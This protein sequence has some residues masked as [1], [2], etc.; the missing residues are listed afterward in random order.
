MFA[1]MNESIDPV[2]SSICSVAG[3]YF[4][5]DTPELSKFSIGE[6]AHA[7][8][9]ICRFTGHT[10][11]FYSVAQHSVIVSRIVPEPYAL[12]GL[13]HDAAEAFIGDVSTPLKRLLPDYKTIE[14]RVEEAV[15]GRF[16]LSLPLHPSVKDADLV[17]LAT[18][19][20]DLMPYTGDDWPCLF[21]VRPLP[22]T[23]VPLTPKDAKQ[24]FLNRF[25][26]L[27][28]YS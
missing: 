20:R 6:I 22:R 4:S 11:D 15:L 3:H 16:G 5:F 26:E 12:E 25:F 7:L 23:I 21:M 24:S 19:R 27:T 14:R 8:S 13:L 9:N 17:A 18:E 2:K 1:P 28:N 10:R